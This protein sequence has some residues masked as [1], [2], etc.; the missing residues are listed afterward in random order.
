MY[1]VL[2]RDTLNW[3]KDVKLVTAHI[4]EVLEFTRKYGANV[5]EKDLNESDMVEVITV[6]GIK[7]T[8]M[9]D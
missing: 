6:D 2:M 3:M 4:V 9:I 8:I 5:T 1:K 7:I